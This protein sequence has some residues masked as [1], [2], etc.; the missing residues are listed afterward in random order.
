M[1]VKITIRSNELSKEELQLLIQAIHDCEQKSFPDK[2]I[3][4]WIDAPDLTT[5]EMTEILN[6]IKPGYKYGSFHIYLPPLSQREMEVLK[7][8]AKGM[9]NKDIADKLFISEGTVHVHMRNIFNK[10]GVGSRSKAILYSLQRGWF[11]IEDLV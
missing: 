10:L 1:E 2:E 5:E 3:F 8:A 4:I 7:I 6:S 9:S 11:A